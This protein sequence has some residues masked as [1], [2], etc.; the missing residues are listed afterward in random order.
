MILSF[1]CSTKAY[2][3]SKED[4]AL[5]N[6]LIQIDREPDYSYHYQA[7]HELAEFTRFMFSTY[8]YLIS[9]QSVQA[10]HFQPSCSVYAVQCVEDHGYVKGTLMAF[11][12]MLRC[13]PLAL[14]QYELNMENGL[15]IDSVPSPH[16]P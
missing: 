2:S 10:C 3:Q 7:D 5:G 6:D 14:Q 4:L 12:R 11:D 1:L 9:S 15:A 16:Q 8:K 13:H